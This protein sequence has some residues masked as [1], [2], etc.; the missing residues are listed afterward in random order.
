MSSKFKQKPGT[1]S[2]KLNDTKDLLR[3]EGISKGFPGVWENLI[4]DAIDFKI[5]AGEVHTL[6]GE[7]GAGKTVLANILSGYYRPTQGRIYVGGKSVTFDSPKDGLQHG[8]A[9]VHQEVMLAGPLTVAEN[10]ALGLSV[11]PFSY[12]L[13]S[14]EKEV[15]RLSKDFGLEVDPT[16]RVADLSASG[17]QRA[18]I[19]K[20]L[21]YQPQVLILDE[22]T[23][24]LTPQESQKLFKILRKMADEDY[25]I[26]FITHKLE[27]IMEV[28]DRITVLR[29]GKVVG[30]KLKNK[31]SKEE[32]TRMM[33]GKIVPI[34]LERELIKERE[35]PAMKVKNIHVLG[36][37]KE[38][39]L[40]GVS[41]NLNKSE[42]LGIAGVSG[43]G[44]SELLEALTGLRH[45]ERGQVE[46]GGKDMTNSSP[47]KIMEAGAAHIPEK[48]REVGVIEPMTVAENMVL[49]DYRKH[50]F[51]NHKVLDRSY[52]T[53]HTNELISKFNVIVPDLWKTEARILSGG[54]IQ[55]LILGRETW[56]E[57]PL[58][59]ASHPTHGL[60]RKAVKHT[61]D[62][63]L[64][65]RDKGSAI[66]LV[67]S[68]L[69]E[70]MTLSDRIAVIFEGQ[71]MKIFDAQS[72][73]KEKIGLLM[74]GV[75]D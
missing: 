7:N 73:D 35:K 62:L 44:Q 31:T 1:H 57:P 30:Q 5:R 71:I 63:F 53:E 42:I 45:I 47:R 3:A 68:D 64:K 32:L 70:I 41:F 12:P 25:G 66:L 6:L 28:S 56:R 16:A 24:L 36:P 39:A 48:R 52:I 69:G 59:L 38:E 14:V 10:V 74:A 9:M 46:Y 11:T 22:P 49:R 4:L 15:G 61:W 2:E 55:R 23:S 18:E 34:Q 8:I 67:S 50:P 19:L 20:V 60:D 43:N 72:A 21:Y 33:L 29:L 37:Y 13:K 65:L 58:I 40:K 27:E 26:V 75:R 51:S 17:M 54:N